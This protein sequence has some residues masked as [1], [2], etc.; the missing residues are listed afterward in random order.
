MLAKEQSSTEMQPRCDGV[1]IAPE[2][3]SPELIAAAYLMNRMQRLSKESLHD[4]ASLAPEL[5]ECDSKEKFIEIMD[6][7]REIIFPELLG[8]IQEGEPVGSDE[9]LQ[10]HTE[11]ISGKIKDLRKS[12]GMTQHD[13]ADKSGLP[14]S[15][16]S[17]IENAQHSPSSKT[18]ERLANALG[19]DK[20]EL[21]P[22]KW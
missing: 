15:H 19:V 7:I 12:A 10:K 11:W 14:Q 13:L 2:E 18:L 21:D 8:N 6:A 22:S 4:L 5:A 3:L 17:R 16:I 9:T 20:I 1:S